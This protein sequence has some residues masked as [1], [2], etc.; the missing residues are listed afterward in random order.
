MYAEARKI[1]LIEA[2]LKI[3]NEA[4][5]VELETVLKKSKSEREKKVASAH[6]FLGVWSKKDTALIVKA[7]E[8]TCEQIHEDDWK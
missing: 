6:E 7:I 4:T 1:H 5:L 8:E 3:S 2:V